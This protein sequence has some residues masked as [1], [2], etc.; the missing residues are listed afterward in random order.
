MTS[1][2]PFNNM[3]EEIGDIFQIGAKIATDGYT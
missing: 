3:L 1:D 2:S